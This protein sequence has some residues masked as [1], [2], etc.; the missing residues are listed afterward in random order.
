MSEEIKMVEITETPIEQ[1]E[2]TENI[3]VP[4]NEF[5]EN[6]KI[7]KI[8]KKSKNIKIPKSV[9]LIHSIITLLA[10]AALV[11]LLVK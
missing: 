6:Y 2:E 11:I 10:L 9:V 3:K 7:P 5:E 4:P 8:K 1:V